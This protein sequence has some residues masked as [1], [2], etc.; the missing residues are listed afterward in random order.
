MPLSI[1]VKPASS[2]CNLRCEYCFYTAVAKKRE[3][4]DKGMLSLEASEKMISSAFECSKDF[5]GFV[6]QGGEPLLCSLDFYK[7]FVS[8][9]KSVN[10]KGSNIHYCLQTNGTLITNEYA[11]FF[12]NNNFLIG[13]SLDG[14]EKLNKYRIYPNGKNSFDDILKGIEILKK[15]NVTFNVLSVLTKNTALNFRKAY[16]FFK[17]NDL[18]YIQFIVGLKPFGDESDNDMYMSS[19]DYAYFLTKGFNIY[20]NEI[21]NIK[22]K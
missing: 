8:Y 16:R 7:N 12:K 20:Y 5:V 17:S 14:D 18:K 1:M 19:D 10:K 6:F 3:I 9:A 21:F 15:H 22:N 11:D 2:A 4:F 13:V